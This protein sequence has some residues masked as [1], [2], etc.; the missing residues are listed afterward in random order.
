MR[1][2]VLGMIFGLTHLAAPLAAEA[3]RAPRIPRVGV[4]YWNAFPVETWLAHPL[5]MASISFRRAL[6]PMASIA[7][8]RDRSHD[9]SDARH[10]VL[11][12]KPGRGA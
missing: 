5:I 2:P 11:D 9:I 7:T 12:A 6:S 8:A 10:V 1:H 3:E 4:V